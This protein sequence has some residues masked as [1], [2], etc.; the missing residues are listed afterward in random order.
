MTIEP[1]PVDDLFNMIWNTKNVAQHLTLNRVT[2][3]GAA[4][5]WGP[6]NDYVTTLNSHGVWVHASDYNKNFPALSNTHNISKN[7][8]HCR[9]LWFRK[10]LR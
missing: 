9:H 2:T 1:S 6:E 7:V 4:F 10:T 5:G 3:S 8:W